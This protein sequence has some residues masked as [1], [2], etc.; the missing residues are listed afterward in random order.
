MSSILSAHIFQSDFWS[1]DINWIIT[2]DFE[3]SGGLGTS[4]PVFNEIMSLG[5]ETVFMAI[6]LSGDSKYL[7]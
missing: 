1:L 5:T 4:R 6:R 7:R 3:A 2:S